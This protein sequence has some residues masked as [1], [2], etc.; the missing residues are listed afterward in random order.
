MQYIL[1]LSFPSLKMSIFKQ[2]CKTLT[3][4]KLAVYFEIL[5][6]KTDMVE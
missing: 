1:L 4:R 2:I 5:N 6:A 3:W